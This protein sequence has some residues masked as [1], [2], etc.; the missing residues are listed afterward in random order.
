MVEDGNGALPG[1]RVG[2]Q[3]FLAAV[4]CGVRWRA[5]EGT[6]ASTDEAP[7]PQVPDSPLKAVSRALLGALACVAV[8]PRPEP[9]PACLPLHA[10]HRPQSRAA[11]PSTGSQ[12]NWK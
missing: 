3:R 12:R 6:L 8:S 2:A 9:S 5:N 7:F 11:A 10:D 1:R 4:G